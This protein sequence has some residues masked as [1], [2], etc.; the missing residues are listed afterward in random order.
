LATERDSGPDILIILIPPLPEGVA[1]A[2]IVSMSFVIRP[3]QAGH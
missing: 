1:T 3:C 2:Q